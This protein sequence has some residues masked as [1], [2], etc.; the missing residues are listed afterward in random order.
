MDLGRDLSKAV[1]V[2]KYSWERGAV[3]F[4]D[5]VVFCDL[6]NGCVGL[7]L[8]HLAGSLWLLHCNAASWLSTW[9]ELAGMPWGGAWGRC[10]KG[11]GEGPPPTLGGT[12]WWWCRSKMISE[13]NNAVLCLCSLSSCWCV[14]PSFTDIRT[15]LLHSI[16]HQWPAGALP[17]LQRQVRDVEVPLMYWTVTRFYPLWCSTG[18]SR[19]CYV[20]WSNKLPPLQH[21]LQYTWM[22]HW[23]IFFLPILFLK[24]SWTYSDN[25]TSKARCRSVMHFSHWKPSIMS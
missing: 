12:F 25:A 4:S 11:R 18:L 8:L 5:P 16:M 21:I 2:G 1:D 22:Y 6:I 7:F 15:Q 20:S 14:H 17:A 24:R 3:A 23:Y 10:Q 19:P 9:Q 13:K